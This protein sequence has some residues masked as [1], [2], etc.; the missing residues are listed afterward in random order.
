[1]RSLISRVAI[2]IMLASAGWTM[3]GPGQALVASAAPAQTKALDVVSCAGLIAVAKAD[4]QRL[5]LNQRAIVDHATANS[6][7]LTVT[8]NHAQ[9]TSQDALAGCSGFWSTF[10]Y[11][12]YWYGHG[13]FDYLKDHLN[14]GFCTDGYWVSK[15]WGPDCQV[16]QFWL[17]GSAND[18][19][20]FWRP[21]G[22]TAPYLQMGN[23]F[24]IFPYSAPWINKY[25]Y[26]RL[27]V[28]SDF[29]Y[30]AWGACCA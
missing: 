7:R 10:S 30:S 3:A 2:S 13:S 22:N 19:C 5:T 12:I 1:M 17:W 16:T 29:S 15:D 21:N 8:L 9:P 25:G 23:N 26:S 4:R 20:G 6:C 14:G 11:T 24:H 18:W 28:Y 27:E